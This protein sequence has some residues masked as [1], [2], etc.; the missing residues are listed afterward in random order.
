M[1]GA[2]GQRCAVAL[3]DF[4]GDTSVGDLPF[5]AGD[6]ITDITTVS[7]EWMSGRIG[8]RTGTFPSAFVQIT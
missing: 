3:Y 6:A 2:S 5:H 1:V 4:D 8:Q 7:E